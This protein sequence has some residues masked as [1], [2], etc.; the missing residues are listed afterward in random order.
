MLGGRTAKIL[1]LPHL[2][3]ENRAGHIHPCSGTVSVLKASP[4][5]TSQSPEEWSGITVQQEY[6]PL[7]VSWDSSWKSTDKVWTASEPHPIHIPSPGAE[8]TPFI[9]CNLAWCLL[10][11]TTLLLFCGL[12]GNWQCF[13]LHLT[14]LWSD[15]TGQLMWFPT[16]TFSGPEACFCNQVSSAGE[17]NIP[18]EPLGHNPIYQSWTHLLWAGGSLSLIPFIHY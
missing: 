11:H 15:I 17:G 2:V 9:A 13:Y 18:L 12:W 5:Y 16:R 8:E 1:P 14:G 7:Q 3:F 4:K 6:L 10:A